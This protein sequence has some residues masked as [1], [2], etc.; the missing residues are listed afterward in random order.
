VRALITRGT[1]AVLIVRANTA[2]GI[3]A[4]REISRESRNSDVECQ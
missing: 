2:K 1:D 3:R 4:E